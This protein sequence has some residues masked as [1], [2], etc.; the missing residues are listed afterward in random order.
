MRK[1]LILFGI[2]VFVV[3]VVSFILQFLR[4]LK[5]KEFLYLLQNNEF[6]TLYKKIDSFYTKTIFPEYNREYV[7]LN[8]LIMQDRKEEINA[9][10]DKLIPMAK[11]KKAWVDI[12]SKAF[13]YYVYAEDKE[14]CDDILKEIEKLNDEKILKASNLMYDVMILKKSNHIEEMENKFD[15]LTVSQKV[16]NA[17]L[18]SQQYR[19]KGDKEKAEYYENISKS[20]VEGKKE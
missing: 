17:Y 13:E 19:N 16:I 20:L 4:N 15:K 12:L 9:A 7:R 5:Q 14:R 3:V 8:A 10:F 1:T 18:L 2:I 6:D 11:D